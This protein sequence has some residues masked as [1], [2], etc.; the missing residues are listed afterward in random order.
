MPAL[1]STTQHKYVDSQL[2]PE[3]TRFEYDGVSLALEAETE[4]IPVDDDPEEIPILRE[5]KR[6]GSSRKASRKPAK[7]KVQTS[8]PES[9]QVKFS[10]SDQF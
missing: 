10:R 7:Y 3:D 4:Y 2:E 6:R 5:A 9:T 1:P 8:A